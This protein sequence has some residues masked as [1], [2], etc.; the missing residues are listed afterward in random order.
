VLGRVGVP[1][2]Q[3]GHQRPR[4]AE[5]GGL[6]LLEQRGAAQRRTG[7]GRAGLHEPDVVLVEG[8]DVELLDVDDAPQRLAD[9]QGT[10]SSERTSVVS[11]VSS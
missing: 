9:R 1:G 5:V 8:V 4:G 7:L 2:L 11:G 3:G 10:T 6:E